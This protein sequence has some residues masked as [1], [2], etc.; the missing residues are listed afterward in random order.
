MQLTRVGKTLQGASTENK[1]AQ[2]DKICASSAE[3][4]IGASVIPEE[5]RPPD[6]GGIDEEVRTARQMAYFFDLH[7]CQNVCN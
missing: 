1:V 5:L 6:D 3:I 2:M 4:M 7:V